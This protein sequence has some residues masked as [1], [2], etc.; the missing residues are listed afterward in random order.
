MWQSFSIQNIK[1]K[2][3]QIRFFS[4]IMASNP[5][6]GGYVNASNF[7]SKTAPSSTAKWIVQG[8]K[9]IDYIR[10]NTLSLGKSKSNRSNVY[11]S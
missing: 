1:N 8:G 9:L 6:G 7:T 5:V 11:T 2:K 10:W 4:N 3:L